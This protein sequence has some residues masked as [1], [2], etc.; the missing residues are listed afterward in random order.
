MVR[1]LL[2]LF[3]GSLFRV[4]A[5]IFSS[6]IKLA[7]ISFFLRLG[8]NSEVSIFNRFWP[9]IQIAV[10][11]TYCSFFFFLVILVRLAAFDSTNPNC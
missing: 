9:Y 8:F 5:C 1:V 7:P 4:T 2:F 3:S 11:F 6:K 10:T